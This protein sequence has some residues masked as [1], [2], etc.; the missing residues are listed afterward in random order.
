MNADV[1]PQKRVNHENV[2]NLK[3]FQKLDYFQRM[4]RA[5]ARYENV[6]KSLRKTKYT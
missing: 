6:R 1:I 2:S 5:K 4:Q 3:Y